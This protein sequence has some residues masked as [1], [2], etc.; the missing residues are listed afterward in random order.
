MRRATD[1]LAPPYFDPAAAPYQL[2]YL[3]LARTGASRLVLT[4]VSA[5]PNIAAVVAMNV[6]AI[7]ADEARSTILIDT[8]VKTASVAAALRCHAEPG[9]AD[10]I[11]QRIDWSEVTTQ[12]MVGRDRVIDVIPSGISSDRRRRESRD[13]TRQLSSSAMWRSPKR[14]FQ[15]P[16]RYQI[17]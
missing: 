17:P 10:V 13:T 7:A 12:T 14:D 1:R 6:A 8:G 15:V 11:Q 4:V 5:D 2:T 16:C 3:H 9:L